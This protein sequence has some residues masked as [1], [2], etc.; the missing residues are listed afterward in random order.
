MKFTCQKNELVQAIQNVSKAV[1]SKPQMPIL[2][3]IYLKAEE[4]QLEW[5]SPSRLE[6]IPLLEDLKILLP[7]QRF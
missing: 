7:P 6:Q 2:S 4:G 1:A 3:G 5:I